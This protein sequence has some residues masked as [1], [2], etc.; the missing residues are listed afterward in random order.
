MS[1]S[2]RTRSSRGQR[3]SQW[4]SN[5]PASAASWIIA[6]QVASSSNQAASSAVICA[7]NDVRRTLGEASRTRASSVSRVGAQTPARSAV[8]AASNSWAPS[9]PAPLAVS[10]WSVASRS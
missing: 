9:G 2:T 5:R 1:G 8:W 3:S 6:A 10:A 4:R 7:A